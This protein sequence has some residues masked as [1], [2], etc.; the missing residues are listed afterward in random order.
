M[1]NME[2]IFD[3]SKHVFHSEAFA[4]II[5][6]TMRFFNGTPVHKL[7]PPENFIGAG[8]Y[9]LYYTGKSKYY[10][11]L[12]SINRVSFIQPIYVGKAVPRG[13]RQGRSQDVSNELYRRLCDHM[14]SIEQVDN[15]QI[16]DFHCR[17]MI[18]EDAAVD[19]IGTVEAALIR[20]YTPIWNNMIDGF[21]NHDPGSG[22]YEQ[23]MSDW[24]VLHPGRS[25]AGR[26]N[27]Q[28]LPLE[29]VE[30]K[31]KYYFDNFHAKRDL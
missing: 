9:A 26:L 17:F 27:G 3:R 15:L 16:A 25:W 31:V 13:W 21:G 6:D 11:P 4:E 20:Y 30:Q 28:S 12:Y 29:M 22:R 24:D 10:K 5:K 2:N 14:N 1:H 8:I 7:P 18:L 19:M 23:A